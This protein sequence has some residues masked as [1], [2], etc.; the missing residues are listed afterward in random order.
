MPAKGMTA[1]G[2]SAAPAVMIGARINRIL[3]APGGVKSSLN[4]QLED[5]GQR[6]EQPPG[7]YPVG[8]VPQLDETQDLA[9]QEYRV[10]DAGK[11]DPHHHGDLEDA[12]QY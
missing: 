3:L 9:F 2:R 8:A 6:L 4:M 12:D 11:Q 1:K 10:G 7:A 5:V